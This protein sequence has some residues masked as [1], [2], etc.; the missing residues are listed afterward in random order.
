M[1]RRLV[2]AS[3]LVIASA[4]PGASQALF[5]LSLP[6]A[7]QAATVSQRIGLTD[8]SIT[9]HRPG[10][11]G[12]SVWGGLV[13]YGQVWRAGANENT[14]IT[15]GSDATV[16]GVHVPAGSYGLHMI[17][18]ANEW[19][20][21]LSREHQAWGS[22]FYDQ[23][24]DA[25]R[26][27]VKPVSAP[28]EER[29]AYTF[30]DPTD[31]SVVATL[32]WEKLAVPF[33]IEVE[34]PSVVLTSLQSQLRGAAGFNW[35]AFAQAA[36]WCANHKT[37]L[38]QAQAWAERAVAMNKSF[39]SV[40]AQSVVANARGDA[41]RASSLMT[42]ALALATEPD[43]NQYGYELLQGGKVTQALDIFRQNVAANPESW[44]AH[45]SLGEGL[46]TSGDKAAAAAEYR[47]A[48]MMVKD[49]TN[50]KRIDGILATLG[51][52]K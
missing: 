14:V 33:T 31:T 37:G 20:I 7:S 8:L 12:R 29:L 13:P 4:R 38:D 10:I 43:L 6:L 24:D 40:R 44:N 30:D 2:V 19:T 3:C 34:T 42:D 21:I 49:E 35:R 46:A 1:L 47:K 26:F 9:Y 5:P 51:G 15:L 25:A 48:R 11:A 18:T 50:Q 52:T 16:G 41:A 23:K 36:T 22:F 32:R 27:T 17:P 45:D 39:V 28:F